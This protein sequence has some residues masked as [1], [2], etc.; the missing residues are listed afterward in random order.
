MLSNNKTWREEVFKY[1]SSNI[2]PSSSSSDDFYE[3]LQEEQEQFDWW[4][5]YEHLKANGKWE[6]P[7][8]L[9]A[10]SL[11]DVRLEPGS[12]HWHAMQTNLEYLLMLDVDRLVWSFRKLAGLPTPGTPYGGWEEPKSELRGH[13]VGHYMSATAKMWASTRNQTVH[14]RMSAVVS[15]LEKCQVKIG[16]GYLSAF[17]AEFFDRFEAVKYV[18]APYYTIHKIMVGLLDVYEYAGKTKALDIMT[19]M[20]EYFSERVKNVIINHS[21]ERHWTSLNEETGGMNDVLYR[22]YTITGNKKHLV[23][24]HLFDKPCFLGYLALKIDSLSG[25]HA[26]THIPVVIGGQNRY[27]ITGDPLYKDIGIT[28][29]DFL[30]SSHMYAT[31][32]SNIGEHWS[33]PNRLADTL[34]LNNEESCT[35]YNTLK[36]SRHLFRWNKQMEY[37]DHYERALTN[38]VLPI[39][40]GREPGVMLY[41]LPLGKGVSKTQSSMPWG[42]PFDSFWCCYGTAIE[43]FS[44]MGDSIYFEEHGDPLAL[45]IIQYIASTYNWTSGKMKLHLKVHPITTSDARLRASLTI[46]IGQSQTSLGNINIRIPFWTVS[47]GAKA[48]LNN[49]NLPLP[50]PSNFLSIV[51]EWKQNDTVTLDLPVILRTETIL[52]NIQ[53]ILFGPYLLVGL[54][55]GDWDLRTGSPNSSLS[56][57]IIPVPPSYKNLLITLTQ[58]PADDDDA[59]LAF[60]H[61]RSSGDSIALKQ[62]PKPGTNHAVDATFRLVPVDDDAGPISSWKDLTG[63]S[64]MLEPFGLPGMLVAG[65]TTDHILKVSTRMDLEACNDLDSAIFKLQAGLDGHAESFSLESVTNKGCFVFGLAH[66]HGVTLKCQQQVGSRRSLD[67]SDADF[68]HAASFKVNAPIS[69]YHSISFIAKGANRDFLLMPFFSI[70]DE[71]YTVYFD[72]QP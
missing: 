43:S 22:L 68:Q 64:V 1:Y 12:L 63:K 6:R 47:D 41:F 31:G 16:S 52:G 51:R 24:A 20:V 9:K 69:N 62:F 15:A 35:T 30:N 8:I 26:N 32:G 50:S 57:W 2:G 53:A 39:Q 37:A 10:A 14:D 72:I 46:S 70:T 58:S 48:S 13:F 54:S 29:L 42:T 71:D 66:G 67:Y 59:P 34:D 19:W 40:R 65:P 18:W 33:D 38:G 36:V 56:D 3:E 23:M 61:S 11:H 4:K 21:I 28:F 49:E 44:K 60:S 5:L 27:E 7:G 25:F 55:H 45:Y 17:P